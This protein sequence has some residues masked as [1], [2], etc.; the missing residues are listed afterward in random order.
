MT[1]TKQILILSLVMALSPIWA[2]D[3]D[4]AT[5][6]VKNGQTIALALEG[7]YENYTL[8]KQISLSQVEEIDTIATKHG[9]R[10]SGFR[11]F[12]KS[13]S[14]EHIKRTWQFAQSAVQSS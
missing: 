12:E 13:I 3:V 1:V 7:R 6:P 10:L 11:S 14:A 5:V 8:G 4:K 9:F 2:K